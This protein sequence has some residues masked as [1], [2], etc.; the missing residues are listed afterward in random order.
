MQVVEIDGS[1]GEGGGQIVRTACSLAAVTQKPCHIFNIRHARRQPGLRPQHLASVRAL[2]QLCGASLTGGAVDSREI[3]FVPG[4]IIARDLKLSIETAGS[5]TLM[6]QAL[7]PA[8]FHSDAPVTIDFEGGA[9]DTARAPSLDYFAHVLL[10]FLERIGLSVKIEVDR[11]G[12]YPKGGAAMRVRVTPGRPRALELMERGA[13]KQ[14]TLFSHAALILKPRKV[15]E[16]QLDGALCILESLGVPMRSNIA[17]SPSFSAGSSICI[18]A[19]F[20]DTVIGCDSLGA[21]G[22]RAE[23]VGREAGG[24]FLAEFRG[25]FCLDRHMADQILPYLA[26]GGD[27]SSATVSE[28]TGHCR[29]NMWVIE[30]F[31]DGHFDLHGNLI[32]WRDS[33]GDDQW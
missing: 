1:Y 28:L 18:V 14:V 26:L 10:W 12:Y 21:R 8:A 29:T 5:I 3:L 32:V 19:E 7:L 2:A 33:Q 31:L 9:S 25:R 20:E 23:D 15:A 13:I 30:R 11:R 16:R 17:Y 22:K 6:L 27:G 24:D 4:Q